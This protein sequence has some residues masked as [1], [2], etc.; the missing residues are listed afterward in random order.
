MAGIQVVHTV[1]VVIVVVVVVV[2]VVVFTLNRS[3]YPATSVAPPVSF[4]IPHPGNI[5]F[6]F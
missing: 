5:L 2:V 1:V 6:N 4:L 3:F